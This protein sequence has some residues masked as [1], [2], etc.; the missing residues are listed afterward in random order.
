MSWK[1]CTQWSLPQLHLFYNKQ[2]EKSLN[3]QS[4]NIITL[5][6][7]IK[8][9][10][11]LQKM[12]DMHLSYKKTSI[13][14]SSYINYLIYS[15]AWASPEKVALIFVNTLITNNQSH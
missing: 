1:N 7:I 12:Q 10:H 14:Q 6:A 11:I 5:E 2:N 8:K 4:T 3:K 9:Y 13:S 15:L